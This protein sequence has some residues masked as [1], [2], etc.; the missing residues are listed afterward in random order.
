TAQTDNT[1]NRFYGITTEINTEEV[2]QVY[3]EGL[4][5][6]NYAS[7]RFYETRDLI[8][9]TLPGSDATVYPIVDYDYILK[10]PIIGG[11]LSF[12]SNA[13]ALTNE[14]GTNSDRAIVQMNWRRQM[15][16]GIGEVFTPFANLRGDV[17]E[18]NDFIDPS[19]FSKENGALLFGNAVAGIE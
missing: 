16:D 17:Y 4:A 9:P 6:R 10:Q 12:N 18:V 7:M 5:D 15:I 3:L 8:K 2:S 14:D 19:D 13:M 11:E 1:F